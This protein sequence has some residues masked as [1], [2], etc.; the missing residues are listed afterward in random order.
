MV[1]GCGSGEGTVGNGKDGGGFE[2][3]GGEAELA[4]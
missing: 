2:R 3:L 4:Y 1:E